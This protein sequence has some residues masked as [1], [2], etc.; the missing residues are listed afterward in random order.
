MEHT[1]F[2]SLIDEARTREE[3]A[4]ALVDVLSRLRAEEIV[5]FDAWYRAYD[6]V[7]AREDL[8]AAVYAIRGGCSDDSFDDF[9]GW[10]ISRGEAALLT[11][12]RDP[13]SL[14]DLVGNADPRDEAMRGAAGRAYARVAGGELP[15]SAAREI[16]GRAAWPADRFEAG[17]TWD[18]AFYAAQFPALH[19]RYIAPTMAP[20]R[21]ADAIAHDAFWRIVHEYH[22]RGDQALDA[23]SN[24]ELVGFDRWLSAYN[25]ALIRND[26][27]A[28]SR[29]LLG[30]DTPQTATEFRGWLLSCGREVTELAVHALDAIGERVGPATRRGEL[31]YALAAAYRRR[32]KYGAYLSADERE[33][34]PGRETW[35]ADW[36]ERP[37]FAVA[38]LRARLPRLTAGRTDAELG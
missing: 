6:A 9:R 8:W 10:L 3:P 29:V 32:G 15:A 14:A 19:A 13:E 21:R 16:P 11:A 5:A 33:P 18:A 36:S 2:W 38:L 20:A 26:L 37:P 28:A 25:Q 12:I 1:R 17:L 24:D 4:R 27:R 30:D 34:I 22:V 7:V 35:A 31:M 23:L